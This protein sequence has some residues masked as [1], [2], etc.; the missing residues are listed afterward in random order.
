MNGD[1]SEMGIIRGCAAFGGLLA[2]VLITRAATRANPALMML[3]GYLGFSLVGW[4]F[5]NATFFTTAIG[6]YFVLFALTGIPNVTSQIG[7][8]A[9]AQRVCPPEIR[10]RLSGVLSA[11][12]AVGAAIGT[13]AVGLLL[14]HINVVLLFNIQ[15][16][17]FFLCGV[18]TLLFIVRN[19]DTAVATKAPAVE[20]V[21][22]SQ[23]PS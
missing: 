16:L 10:G 1:G 9:T 17:M 8:Q 15:T 7:A 20:S 23:L 22:S 14:D 3:W 13:I 12:G 18:A 21:E 5:I 11:T 6:L 4:S 2:S 19:V